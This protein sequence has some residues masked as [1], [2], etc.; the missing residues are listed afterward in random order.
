MPRRTRPGKPG[1][2]PLPDNVKRFR[3]TF[4]EDRANPTQPKVVGK[5][6]MPPGLSPVAKRE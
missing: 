6:A 3:G 2:K 5:A 4:R 1:P